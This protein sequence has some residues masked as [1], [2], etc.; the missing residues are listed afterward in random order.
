[1]MV[2]VMVVVTSSVA[3]ARPPTKILYSA[4]FPML[5]YCRHGEH[6]SVMWLGKRG[7][8]WAACTVMVMVMVIANFD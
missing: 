2:V 5:S 3:Q 8:Y 4:Y 6:K 1:V 7:E